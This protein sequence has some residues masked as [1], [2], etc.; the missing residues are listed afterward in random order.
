[1]RCDEFESMLQHRCD[2]GLA[3]QDEPQLA[4]HASSC[5]ACRQQLHAFAV[6]IEAAERVDEPPVPNDLAARVQGELRAVSLATSASAPRS[7]RGQ[8]PAWAALAA[9]LLIAAWIGYRVGQHQLREQLIAAAIESQLQSQTAN[10]NTTAQTLE[11]WPVDP[12]WLLPQLVQWNPPPTLPSDKHLAPR[13][14]I[15]QPAAND[16][17]A[18]LAPVANS[19]TAALDN[20]WQALSAG[21]EDTRS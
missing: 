2:E 9:S 11:G 21:N 18:S 1:M 5:A 6:L 14:G 17:R 8:V 13:A 10:G 12:R 4:E 3:P 7:W 20:L 19:A 16:V 15:D